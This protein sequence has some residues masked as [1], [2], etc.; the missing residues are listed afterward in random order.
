MIDNRCIGYGGLTYL[1]WENLRAEISFLVDPV[2]AKT[3]ATYSKDFFHFLTLL[4]Q[5]AFEDLG[6]HRLLTET[7]SFRKE[8]I[9]ILEDF[10]FKQEGILREH[11]YK[12]HQWYD[13]IIHGLLSREWRRGQ[14]EMNAG[15]ELEPMASR[16][17]VLITSISKK[18]PLIEAVRERRI[19]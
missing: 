12:R 3:Q 9:K 7:F 4:T 19:N 18:M 6:L 2:R 11:I 5:V 1:N 13:S 14:D 8:T 16:P 15:D 17:A 10:G